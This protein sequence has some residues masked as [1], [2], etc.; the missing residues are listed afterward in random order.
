M[1]K[2]IVAVRK[3]L[4]E[5][6][7]AVAGFRKSSH[8]KCLTACYYCCTKQGIQA[9]AIEFLPLAYDLYKKGEAYEVWQKLQDNSDQDIC[10]LLVP[11]L[12][13]EQKLV[14]CTQYKHRGLIC[15]MFG[16][17]GFK[18]KNGVIKPALCKPL[19]EQHPELLSVSGHNAPLMADYYY[20]LADIDRSLCFPLL[21]INQAIK[22]AI[23]VVLFYYSFKGKRTG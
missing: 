5:A 3:V 18:D 6:D 11:F 20:K 9:A 8:I 19:K 14:G 10:S 15:R 17:S 2:K 13:H 21:P 12:N 22:K 23:E 7:K 4:A 16:Y 1:Y